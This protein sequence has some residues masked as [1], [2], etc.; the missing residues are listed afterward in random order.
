M[1]IVNDFFM[2]ELTVSIVPAAI[3]IK[4]EDGLPLRDFNFFNFVYH[5]S[6]WVGVGL[7]DE[8]RTD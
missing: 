4:P 3:S 8:H 7:K 2:P 5:I 6:K 1:K